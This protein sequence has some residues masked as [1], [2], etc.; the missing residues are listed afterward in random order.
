[1]LEIRTVPCQEDNMFCSSF[2]Q[3]FGNFAFLTREFRERRIVV[4]DFE[5]G[6]SCEIR[7]VNAS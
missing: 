6:T 3:E 2:S 4:V 7:R 5:V 1:M